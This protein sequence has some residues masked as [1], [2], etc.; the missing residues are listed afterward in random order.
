MRATACGHSKFTREHGA[1][2]NRIGERE[3]G[4]APLHHL[5]VADPPP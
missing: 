3:I 4:H 2:L 5:V 1:M